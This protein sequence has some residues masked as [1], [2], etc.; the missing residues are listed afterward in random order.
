MADRARVEELA[1]AILGA[2][3]RNVDDPQTHVETLAR[4]AAETAVAA[5]ADA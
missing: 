3:A 5:L 2:W 1:R 4:I